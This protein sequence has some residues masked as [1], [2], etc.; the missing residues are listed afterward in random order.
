MSNADV[1]TSAGSGN[2]LYLHQLDVQKR[3][4]HKFD[5]TLFKTIGDV[6]VIMRLSDN[7][8]ILDKLLTMFKDLADQIKSSLDEI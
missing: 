1:K 8:E 3:M 5:E 4:H 7:V 2:L 6:S